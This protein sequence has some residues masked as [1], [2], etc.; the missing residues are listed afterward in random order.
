MKKAIIAIRA[1]PPATD[2]PMMV[3]VPMPESELESDG[4]A[5]GVLD[6]VGAEET[7]ITLVTIC[8]S[9][10]VAVVPTTVFEAGFVVAG[11]PVVVGA[12]LV[13]A[14]VVELD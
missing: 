1:T 8:P 11:G 9:E 7:V 13:V 6:V 4:G 2:K 10:L 3:P 5:D 12:A 14:W